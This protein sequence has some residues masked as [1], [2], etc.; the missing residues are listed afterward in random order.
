MKV[1]VERKRITSQS[2]L[3]KVEMSNGGNRAAF[4]FRHVYCRRPSYIVCNK[5]NQG[6]WIRRHAMSIR[7]AKH[8]LV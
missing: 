5:V 4:K 3:S 2:C 8:E 6:A 1:F 7:C